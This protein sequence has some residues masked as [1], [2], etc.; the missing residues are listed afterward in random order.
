MPTSVY[1][2][3]HSLVMPRV[4]STLDDPFMTLPHILQPLEIALQGKMGCQV[5]RVAVFH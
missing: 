1:G 3:G 4:I 2:R 5:G